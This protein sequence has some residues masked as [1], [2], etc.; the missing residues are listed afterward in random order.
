[1]TDPNR[2]VGS[3]SKFVAVRFSTHK[4]TH[5]ERFLQS[6]SAPWQPPL[7]DAYRERLLKHHD[8]KS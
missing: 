1:M 8:R 3:A 4:F 6:L 7:K 2:F 5:R